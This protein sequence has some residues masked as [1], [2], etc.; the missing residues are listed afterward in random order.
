VHEVGL[1]ADLIDACLAEAGDAP[2]ERVVIRRASTTS[3][4]AIR[5]AFAMLTAGGPLGGA[6]LDAEL[7]PVRLAC[8]CGF[9]GPIGPDDDA[10]GGVLVCPGCGA[11][12]RGPR[13]AEIELLAV[14]IAAAPPARGP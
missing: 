4:D 14:E 5:Q 2:V 9:D 13:T 1:V 3:E 12:H 6:R 7:M 11:I 8:G 10:G